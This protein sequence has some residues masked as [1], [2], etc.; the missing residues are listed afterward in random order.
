MKNR[1]KGYKVLKK[2]SIWNPIV[3]KPKSYINLDAGCGSCGG[4][5]SCSSCGSCS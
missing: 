1:I 4:C 3:S 2:Y 5:S